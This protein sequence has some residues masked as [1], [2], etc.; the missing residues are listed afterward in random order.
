MQRTGGLVADNQ[1]HV[2]VFY[3]AFKVFMSRHKRVCRVSTSLH[4]D[5]SFLVASGFFLCAISTCFL[6]R[7]DS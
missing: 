2:S 3:V 5:S 1:A 7:F 4:Y 6:F